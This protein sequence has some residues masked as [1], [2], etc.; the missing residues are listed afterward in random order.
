MDYA[1]GIDL[2]T[3]FTC[4]GVYRNGRVEIIP[5]EQG[6]R[7]TPSCVA[8][9]PTEKLVGEAAANQ[10]AGNPK[11]TIWGIKRIIGQDYNDR[12]VR[13][14]IDKVSFDVVNRD[15]VP[16]VR[17]RHMKEIKTFRPEEISAMILKKIKSNAQIYLGK[18]VKNA[19]IT[20]PAYFNDKQR[21]ATKVAANIAG[22]N[23]LRIIN[24]P[25]AAALTFGLDRMVTQKKNILVYDLGGGTLDVSLL[26]VVNGRFRV[27]STAGEGFLG[28][29][30]FNLKLVEHMVKEVKKKLKV[31]ISN[32]DRALAKLME[33]C[34]VTKKLLSHYSQSTVQVDNLVNGLDFSTSLSRAKFDELCLGMFKKTITP[35]QKVLEEG[36]VKKYRIDDIIMV[37]GSS[38]ICKIQEIV[39]Q[40][41]N[42]KK[43]D[44]RMNPDEAIAEGAAI[45]AAL[46][47]NNDPSIVDSLS[48]VDI[49]QESLGIEVCNNVNSIIIPKS[50]PLPVKRSTEFTT[51]K[52]GQT[53]IR[54]TVLEGSHN[55]VKHNKVLG[56]FI[57]EIPPQPRGV[58]R[59][60]VSFMLDESGILC[61]SAMD[62]KSSN[63][64]RIVITRED[65]KLS[66]K[67][68][69]K[70]KIPSED[71]DAKEMNH[72][73]AKI[74]I[75]GIGFRLLHA[76]ERENITPEDRETLQT[77]STEVFEWVEKN[78]DVST[79][80]YIT[81]RD[82][83]RS[84]LDVFQ[85][86][87]LSLSGE[88]HPPP[89][90][91]EL[92]SY[93]QIS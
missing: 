67:D 6:N 36:K 77:T 28:G 27:I 48:F 41:F 14:L 92:P 79:E 47:S 33:V 17:V 5:N 52:E 88:Q 85:I 19:V 46:L 69:S 63:H 70:M 43:L 71:D 38:R 45:H 4:A 75:I 61:V 55:K 82:F 56:T 81:K 20:V 49:S 42:N 86:N 53:E 16:V 1:I 24:E 30:E 87:E 8:F 54:F 25:T 74:E 10:R 29:E 7:T 32:N 62:R 22:F 93:E 37:G 64:N 13:N 68:I 89:Y 84:L 80:E 57:L 15:N 66:D 78:K 60:D 39:S 35:I 26:E 83:L 91:P 40:H 65:S 31:D 23:V 3:T 44:N 9:T 34:E 11:N 21:Q 76:A 59:I 2:G 73:G 58:P 50:T 90:L 72:L 18:E 51:S 12:H